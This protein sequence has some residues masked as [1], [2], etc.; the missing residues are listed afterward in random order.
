MPRMYRVRCA[1]GCMHAWGVQEEE[2]NRMD[3]ENRGVG[4]ELKA[5]GQAEREA[6]KVARKARTDA[7]SAEAALRDKRAELDA[8]KAAEEEALAAMAQSTQA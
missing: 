7:T 6:G 2:S 4:A 1:N 5:L 8:C 3:A